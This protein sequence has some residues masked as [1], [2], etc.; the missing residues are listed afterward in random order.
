[1]SGGRG[2]GRVLVVSGTTASGKDRTAAVLARRLGGEIIVLDSM[3]VYRGMDLG[4]DKPSPE[5]RGTVPHH[6]LDILDPRESMNLRRYVDLAR[7]A[8]ADILRR[9][10]VPIVAGGTALYL[11][12]FL[13]GVFEGPEADSGFR[14]RLRAEAAALGLPALHERLR[15]I[16][17]AAAAR[18]HPQDYKRIERALEVH[19]LT[20]R[21]ISGLQTQWAGA[22]AL[23]HRLYLLG[24][25]RHVLDRR[26][27]D[28]VDAMFRSGLVEEVRGILERGGFG[29]QS[30]EALGYR[31]TAAHVRGEAGLA[32]TIEL[33]KRHTRRFARRQLTWFRRLAT[34]VRIEGREGEGPEELAGRI[35]EDWR[36]P[37]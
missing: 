19:H 35:L 27:D 1:M 3:K 26:I 7:G 16:D 11:Q 31:E 18:I 2:G 6:L 4:T 17:P 10:A 9:G 33:V 21:P 5:D 22:P 36:S 13:H 14:D 15:G 23:P 20:G 29:P 12:G 24:W 34:A 28:R 37:G 25:D 30:G 8:A 32:E